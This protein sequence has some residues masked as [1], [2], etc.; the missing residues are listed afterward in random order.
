MENPSIEPEIGMGATIMMWSDRH[1]CTIVQITH[2]NKRI[3]IQRDT[4]VKVADPNHPD[5]FQYEYQA[6]PEGEI[7]YASKRKDGR[8][9]LM[10]SK[11]RV[12]LGVRDEYYDLSF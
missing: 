9:R 12:C 8:Y 4:V 1:A 5:Q 11:T 2:N 7:L 10:G 6:N 3:V